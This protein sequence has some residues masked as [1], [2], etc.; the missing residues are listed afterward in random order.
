MIARRTPRC[1]V[2]LLGFEAFAVELRN[3]FCKIYC[4]LDLP[5]GAQ[6]RAGGSPESGSYWV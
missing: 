3:S 5:R 2:Q 6:R 4:I 1:W